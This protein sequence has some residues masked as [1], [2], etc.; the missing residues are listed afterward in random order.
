MSVRI[1]QLSKEIG[2]ANKELIALLRERGY[3]V[4][5]AASTVDNISAESLIKEFGSDTKEEPN[6]NVPKPIETP[7]A[8]APKPAKPSLPAGAIIKSK[9]Q[10]E[11]EKAAKA[12]EKKPAP[13]APASTIKPA[14]VPPAPTQAK[15]APKVPS[16][17]AQPPKVPSA[18]KGPS[19]PPKMPSMSAPKPPAPASEDPVDSEAAE[20]A[21]TGGVIQVKPPI[22]VRDFAKLMGMKPFKLI[23]ELMEMNI[24]ASMNQVIEE[25]VASRLAKA[26]GFTLE[27]RHRGEATEEQKPKKAEKPKVDESALL[28]SRPPVVCILGHVDHGKTTLLDTIRSA[29]VVAGEAGGITQHVG[30][31]QV[32]R[33]AQKITFIDTPGH[34]AFTKMRARGADVTD[35]A[36]LVVAADD[37][38]MPQTEEALSHA[39]RATVP[40]VVAINKMDAKGANVDRVKTQMQEKGIAPEDWGGETIAVPISALKGDGIDQ[41]LEMVLLQ[42]EMMELKAN[43]KCAAEGVIV[44]SQVEMGR[45][46]V[47][48]VI[49]QKG[50]LKAGDALVCG[51]E[52]CK[53]RSMMDAS[54]KTLKAAPPS[55]PVRV[56]G[57]SGTPNAGDTF[58]VVK[59]E[60]EARREAEDN[61]EALKREAAGDR[62]VAKQGGASIDD[63]FAAIAQTQRSSLRVVIKSDVA[64]TAEA[65]AAS[66]EGIKSDKVTLEVIGVD[67]GPVTKNDI[68]LA[69]ASN[70][71]VVGFN[72]KLENGVIGLAKHHGV[73]L[74]QHNIIYEIIDM[75][76]DEM[77][78]QLD[79]ERRE[80]KLGAAEVRQVFPVANKAF[81]AGCMVT[82]GKLVR[83]G[84]ARIMRGGE[85]IHEGKIDTL[86]RFKDDATE[87]RAGYE[88]GVALQGCKDYKEG[89]TIECLQIE[90][91]RA[92]L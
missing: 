35:I 48:T 83:D 22:V 70:A 40:V 37:G 49:I 18:P 62:Q 72:V 78:D 13:K 39:R 80:V 27:I 76:R 34:A 8:E 75:V 77:A 31:Y 44:E 55:T 86:K 63:L 82:E 68:D 67:V 69:S 54:G 47:A 25:D 89:D 57:W 46:S 43:P 64:G 29:N 92:K 24:F 4:K 5:S 91:V 28:E 30:A 90:K 42:A 61:Q 79:P 53:V 21:P 15:P 14:P 26:H 71:C 2:M 12:A 65:L 23:S 32:E 1:Y 58:K 45:G 10:I 38:F 6:N 16:A 52:Y 50:T 3:D 66:L 9:T 59:N 60:R 41:L 81:V 33:G 87:V 73:R 36:I 11:E 51:T 7:K 19:Q 84:F 17:P 85:I 20:S 88:C 74:I 56:I